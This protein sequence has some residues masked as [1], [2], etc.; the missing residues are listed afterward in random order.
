MPICHHFVI[1]EAKNTIALRFQKAFTP[2]VA[3]DL[4]GFEMLAAIDLYN[5]NSVVTYEVDNERSD[6]HLA[7]KVRALQSTRTDGVPN[8][9]FRVGQISAQRARAIA[10]SL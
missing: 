4:S 2:L 6:R 7:S 1:V 9:P 3:L 5:Q 8:D 10:L